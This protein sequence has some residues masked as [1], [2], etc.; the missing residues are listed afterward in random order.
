MLVKV[1]IVIGFFMGYIIIVLKVEEIKWV[2]DDGV[3]E[4]DV[5]INVVVVKSGNWKD[6]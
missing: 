2:I 6:V 3:D 1:V 4:L 5:V